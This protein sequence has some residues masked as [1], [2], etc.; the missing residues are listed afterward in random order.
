MGDIF[1]SGAMWRHQRLDLVVKIRFVLDDETFELAA[2]RS[3]GDTYYDEAA[4]KGQW[5]ATALI[6]EFY[7][8]VRATVWDRLLDD[9]FLGDPAN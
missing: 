6:R 4:I 5:S 3:P 1:S 9:T 7:P 2:C 8:I